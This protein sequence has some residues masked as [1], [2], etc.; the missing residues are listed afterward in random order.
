MRARGE[1]LAPTGMAEMLC[2]D[3]PQ[4]QRRAGNQEKNQILL[5][6]AGR[7]MIDAAQT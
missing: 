3:V 2:H 1:K 6:T 5:V 4:D 7:P